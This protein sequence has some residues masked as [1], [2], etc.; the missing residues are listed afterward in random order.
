M[1]MFCASIAPSPRP[2]SPVV[3]SGQRPHGFL[4]RLPERIE[5]GASGRARQQ[6]FIEAEMKHPPRS[7]RSLP[8]EGA[9]QWVRAA[10][11][12]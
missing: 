2:S 12:H 4:S 1:M 10:G 11:R 3:Q 5:R 6:A 7:L 9:R 8:P